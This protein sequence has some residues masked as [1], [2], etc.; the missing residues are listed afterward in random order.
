VIEAATARGTVVTP[1]SHGVWLR[2]AA[3]AVA[4]VPVL[5]ALIRA[6]ATRGADLRYFALAAAALGSGAL[7]LLLLAQNR[8][9]STSWVFAQTFAIGAVS[10]TVAGWLLGVVLGPGLLIVAAGFAFCVAVGCAFHV[11]AH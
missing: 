3:V 2:S 7:V 4:A 10:A 1:Q 8:L 5:F 9:R 11:R 6:A